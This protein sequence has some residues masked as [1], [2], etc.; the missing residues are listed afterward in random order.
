MPSP[1][2]ELVATASKV[3]V[4]TSSR[5]RL[6]LSVEQEYPVPPLSLDEAI[7]L[8]AER[9][10][11]IRPGFVVDGSR[12]A[13]EAICSRVDQLPLAIELAAARP[14]ILSV[15]QILER[16]DRR[17][18]LLTTGAA[19][20]PERQRTLRATIECELLS[21]DERALFAR[22]AVFSGGG[23]LDAAERICAADLDTLE[24]LIDKSLVRADADP[25][26]EPRF[27]ML[28]TIREF[29]LERLAVRPMRMTFAAATSSSSST[30]SG[31]PR[32]SS[33]ARSEAVAATTRARARQHPSRPA[34]VV[35]RGSGP[36]A[37]VGCPC[38]AVLVPARRY[39]RGSPMARSGRHQ[40]TS[41]RIRGPC[42][43]ARLGGIPGG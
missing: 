26:G 39:Q 34:V 32:T 42:D 33:K 18:S 4:V 7:S 43:R 28:E 40:R 13:V 1:L 36:R 23:T 29:A 30:S 15:E 24:S 6:H 3:D 37:H 17:L 21:E 5:E 2:G 20:A 25:D 19:D 10:R 35:R 11:A 8:F 38:G 27:V 16:L 14:G 31:T 9:A 12:P 22:L 41:V